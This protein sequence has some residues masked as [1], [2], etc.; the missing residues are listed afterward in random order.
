MT[1]IWLRVQIECTESQY[2]GLKV[3]LRELILRSV[4]DLFLQ[5]AE[6]YEFSPAPDQ[7]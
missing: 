2:T 6:C 5:E 7:I 1:K 3:D 4:A